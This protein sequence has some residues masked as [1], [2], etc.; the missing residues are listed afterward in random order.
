MSS[1]VTTRAPVRR[2]CML[3]LCSLIAAGGAHATSPILSTSNVV[4]NS[5]NLGGMTTTSG[6]DVT[7]SFAYTTISNYVSATT[8]TLTSEVQIAP[9]TTTAGLAYDYETLTTTATWD[10]TTWHRDDLSIH[11]SSSGT[12]KSGD[13]W[14]QL[15]GSVQSTVNT[16]LAFS[17]SASGAFNAITTPLG[18]SA[19][20]LA[21]F[22]FG[23]TAPSSLSATT[24]TSLI[25]STYS[26]YSSTYDTVTTFQ[27][28]AGVSQNFVAYVYAPDN[29]SISD[30]NLYAQTDYYDPV[31][32]SMT[33]TSVGP[34]TLIGAHTLAPVPEPASYAMMA[35]GLTLVGAAARRRSRMPA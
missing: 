33:D 9:T 35:V 3:A 27:L 7:T 14:I 8:S 34:K 1:R 25:D 11:V 13:K 19:P 26:T 31:V 22:Y 12:N 6:P 30:F 24:T 32:T 2:S 23:S 5:S 10:Q 29:V 15:T 4:T 20:L 21:S 18:S 16:S 17:L 28:L